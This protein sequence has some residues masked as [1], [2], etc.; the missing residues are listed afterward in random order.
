LNEGRNTLEFTSKVPN[1][2]V[3]IKALTLTPVGK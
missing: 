1:K 3:S 2:G